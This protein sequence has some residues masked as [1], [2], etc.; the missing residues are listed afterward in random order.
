MTSSQSHRALTN[1]PGCTWLDGNPYRRRPYRAKSIRFD[2][3]SRAATSARLN[4]AVSSSRDAAE[5]E[6]TSAAAEARKAASPATTNDLSL[7]A[8]DI[9]RANASIG[10]WV[11]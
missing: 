10:K 8:S 1:L 7:I 2:L 6:R 5:T 4:A 9:D 3:R 11:T